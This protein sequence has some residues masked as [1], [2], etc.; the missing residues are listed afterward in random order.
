[1]VACVVA[2]ALLGPLVSLY[3]PTEIVGTPFG[4][5]SSA[6]VIGTDFLGRDGMSRFLHGGLALVGCAF[7]ATM[8]SYVVGLSLGMVAGYRRGVFDLTTVA[9][10]DLILA[11]PPIVLMLV[12]LAAT[13]PRLSLVVLGIALVF[14]PRVVRISRSVTEEVIVQEYVEAALARGESQTA[15]LRRDV[16][17]NI[18]TPVLADFG[19]RLTGAVILFSS[20]SYLGLGQAPPAADWG[21]MISENRTGLLVQ[22]WLI[23]VPAATIATLSIGINLM[24]DGIARSVG[25]SVSERGV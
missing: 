10:V 1:M 25:R 24:A 22:P 3:S 16:L 7:L 2:L 15:I 13:G 12:L 6:H 23:V 17:P 19:L 18:A 14:A 11:F 21:L 20:I 5:P 8:L 4:A 9:V